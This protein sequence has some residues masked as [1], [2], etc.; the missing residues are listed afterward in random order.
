MEKIRF[1]GFLR[2]GFPLFFPK[3]PNYMQIL[4][5]SVERTLEGVTCSRCV[6]PLSLA[7]SHSFQ[8]LPALLLSSLLLLL[9]ACQLVNYLFFS[10]SFLLS[11]LLLPPL[12][13]QPQ[14][15]PFLHRTP[16]NPLID[17][18]KRVFPQGLTRKRSSKPS[19]LSHISLNE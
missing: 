4:R 2:A 12:V 13:L 8:Q 1:R 16:P 9:L 11:L 6:R 18:D 5:S 3:N 7:P 19:N 14:P 17:V 10:A 15:L